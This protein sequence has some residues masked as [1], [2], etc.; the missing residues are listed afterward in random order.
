MDIQVS[1]LHERFKA[2]NLP[3]RY[4]IHEADT[5][6]KTKFGV[7]VVNPL[8][9]TDLKND[10]LIQYDHIVKIY[11]VNNSQMLS[12]IFT[13]QEQ[14]MIK[15]M[16]IAHKMDSSDE[17]SLTGAERLWRKIRQGRLLRIIIESEDRQ[18]ISGF[19][20]QGMSQQLQ[21]ELYILRGVH[22]AE[23]HLGNDNYE[24]YLKLLH[25]RDYI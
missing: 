15:E 18:Y 2:S 19:T 23:C 4:T 7:V 25:Q 9:K 6:L 17:D 20:L 16:Q 10:P 14:E 12:S 22:K 13:S 1:E 5:R 24:A 8:E 11:H 3:S 21:Q